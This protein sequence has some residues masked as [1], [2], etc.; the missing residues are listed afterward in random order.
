MTQL[1]TLQESL[2]LLTAYEKWEGQLILH[3][4]WNTR[5]GLPKFTQELYDSFMELQA[6]RNLLILG[7]RCSGS[8]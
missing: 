8:L 1:E 5:D 3:G 7:L 4:D 2:A 6:R